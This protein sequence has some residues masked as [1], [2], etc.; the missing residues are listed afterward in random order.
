MGVDVGWCRALPAG[1]EVAGRF[2]D[3]MAVRVGAGRRLVGVRIGGDT[4]RE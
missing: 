4:D 3:D 2:G 1:L